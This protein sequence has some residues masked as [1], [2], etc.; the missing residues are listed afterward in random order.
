MKV[1]KR[2]STKAP[3]KT[4]KKKDS[5]RYDDGVK[6]PKGVKNITE[7]RKRPGMSNAGTYKNVPSKDFAGPNKTYPIN[8]KARAKSALRLAHNAANPAAIKAK[9]YKKYPDLKKKK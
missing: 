4:T 7:L 2:V 3:T 5:R 6:L 8:T 9:V 1:K